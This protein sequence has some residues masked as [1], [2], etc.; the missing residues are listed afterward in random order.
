MNSYVNP[1]HEKDAEAILQRLLP[2]R[3]RHL[4]RPT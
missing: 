3:L 4:L 2:G 1:A